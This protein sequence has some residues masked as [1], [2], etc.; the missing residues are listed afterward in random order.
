MTPEFPYQA[1]VTTAML[2][3]YTLIDRGIEPRVRKEMRVSVSKIGLAHGLPAPLKLEVFAN[4]VFS[5]G[6]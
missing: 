2:Q 1:L 6:G 3:E 4:G 5:D